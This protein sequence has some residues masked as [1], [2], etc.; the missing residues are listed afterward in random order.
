MADDF[1]K[2]EAEKVIRGALKH[3]QYEY[4]DFYDEMR[5]LAWDVALHADL[6]TYT[7]EVVVDGEVLT[8]ARMSRYT[9]AA[10]NRAARQIRAELQ[11][12]G[13]LEPWERQR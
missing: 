10:M 3:A 2:A 1:E 6:A 11:V 8:S 7:L 4:N 12:K 5:D 9:H 13:A